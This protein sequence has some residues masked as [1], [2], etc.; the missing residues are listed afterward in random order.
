M[1]FTP[2]PDRSLVRR[3]QNTD[4]QL[5]SI[6]NQ[7][8]QAL[9]DNLQLA[10]N[11]LSQL[12][13]QVNNIDA[14]VNTIQSTYNAQLSALQT[15]QNDAAPIVAL[16]A[17]RIATALSYSQDVNTAV[18]KTSNANSALTTANTNLTAVS[19]NAQPFNNFLTSIAGMGSRPN[20]AIILVNPS[21]ALSWQS[22]IGQSFTMEMASVSLDRTLGTLGGTSPAGSNNLVPINTRAYI[23]ARNFFG[24]EEVVLNTSNNTVTVPC[25]GG[26]CVYY[27]FSLATFCGVG[28][29]TSRV[30]LDNAL[31]CQGT[32]IQSIAG[33]SVEANDFNQASVGFARFTVGST[34]PLLRLESLVQSNHPSALSAALGRPFG[35]ASNLERY[36]SMVL[37]RRRML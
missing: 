2:Y 33:Q 14:S 25:T 15:A 13:Q 4:E 37:L 9:I 3:L 8:W 7:S 28:G 1:T 10:A 22:S 11:T 20:N 29:A 30:T 27:V 35:S 34:S 31:V 26:D 32:A 12:T 21:G 23:N 17:Q 6:F 5:S 36:A 24:L 16:S 19:E 18:A